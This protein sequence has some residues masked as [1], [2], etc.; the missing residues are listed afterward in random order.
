ML[1]LTLPGQHLSCLKHLGCHPPPPRP[2]PPPVAKEIPDLN[3]KTQIHHSP[4]ATTVL[5]KARDLDITLDETLQI[6]QQEVHNDPRNLYTA[7]AL[8][9]PVTPLTRPKTSTQSA[10]RLSHSLI[11]PPPEPPASMSKQMEEMSD[12]SLAGYHDTTCHYNP[13]DVICSTQAAREGTRVSCRSL[14]R[15]RTLASPAP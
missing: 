7:Q 14:P 9:L 11:R 5:Y 8:G 2:L 4:D 12:L 1:P 10:P 6:S 15:P 13:G 3:V